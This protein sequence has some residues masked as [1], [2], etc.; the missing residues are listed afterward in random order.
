MPGFV[1]EPSAES[2]AFG[3]SVEG[4]GT[5]RLSGELD[6]AAVRELESALA[7]HPP[8]A[9]MVIDMSAVSFM[10]SSGL[11][12]LLAASEQASSHATHVVLRDAGP[13][14]T[15]LLEITGTTEWFALEQNGVDHTV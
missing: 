12:C 3:V 11:R 1:N 10:D 5:I 15:R 9:H 7:S 8:D 13:E 2:H 4:D 14:V 6:L